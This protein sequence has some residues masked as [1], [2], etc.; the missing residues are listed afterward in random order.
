MCS[1]LWNY[2]PLPLT[3]DSRST[4]LLALFPSSGSCMNAS[5]SALFC[6]TFKPVFDFVDMESLGN[7]VGDTCKN[8]LL[9]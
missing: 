4:P 1:D 2:T 5:V 7:H 3:D 9:G 8:L 6:S